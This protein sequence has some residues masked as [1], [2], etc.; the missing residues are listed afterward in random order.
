MH[1]LTKNC[2]H[3]QNFFSEQHFEGLVSPGN[4]KVHDNEPDL[5]TLGDPK[6]LRFRTGVRVVKT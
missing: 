2:F 4:S 1:S 6:Q 5:P 3:F